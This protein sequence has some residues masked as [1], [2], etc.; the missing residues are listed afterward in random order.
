M[1]W[2][3]AI[4]LVRW[5]CEDDIGSERDRG[6]QIVDCTIFAR[7]HM[8][9]IYVTSTVFSVSLL[10]RILEQQACSDNKDTPHKQNRLNSRRDVERAKM[11]WKR[12]SPV[13][14]DSVSDSST[15][16]ARSSTLTSV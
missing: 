11:T 3:E 13:A 14:P 16:K 4:K 6:V 1:R 7:F 2:N 5:V 9:L 12:C 15:S 8:A 10:K